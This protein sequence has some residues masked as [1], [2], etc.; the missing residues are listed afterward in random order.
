MIKDEKI[1]MLASRAHILVGES[2]K[3]T[4]TDNDICYVYTKSL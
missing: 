3:G 2:V 1:K 4:N